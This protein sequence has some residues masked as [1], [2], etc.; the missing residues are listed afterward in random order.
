M[1]GCDDIQRVLCFLDNQSEVVMRP[2][3]LKMV[4]IT[5]SI[6]ILLVTLSIYL[7]LTIPASSGAYAVGQTVYKWV[8]TSRPEEL[9]ANPDDFREIIALI[10]YPAERGT[11]TKSAYFLGLSAVSKALVDSGEVASWE[12]FGLRF[13]RSQNR[14]NAT[15]AKSDHPYPIL[16]F[17]PGNG[18]NMEFYN[19]LASEIA[20]HGYIVIG[21]NH[22]YDVAAVE[23][24]DHTIAQFYEEQESLDRSANQVFIAERIKVMVLDVI[25]ALNQLNDLNA[26]SPFT[27]ILDLKSVAVAGHSLG[28]ITAS[29]ACKADSRFRACLN[30]DGLQKGG[31]F[32]TEETAIPP[33]RPFMFITK[34]AQ[35][36]PKLIEKFK[37]MKESYWVVIHGASHDR[38]TD[39]PLLQP[40]LLPVSNSADQIMVLVQKYTLAF[41]DQTLKGQTS[42]LLSR[43]V[44]LQNISVEVYPSN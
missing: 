42:N 37:S 21:V 3:I 40:S 5:V 33:D 28:G 36:H 9:N 16:I 13:M 32:S 35:L 23:L 15:L 27:G 2:Q 29:E 34:E 20:S 31:A 7:Q 30:F 17:S 41:W 18:T 22:P 25:F 43:S 19:S 11:G 6:L 44:H 10:W 24:S 26:N 39:G 8:D 4:A 38:F 14:A 12:V 1:E